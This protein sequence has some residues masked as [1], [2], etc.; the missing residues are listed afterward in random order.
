MPDSAG[1]AVVAYD[2]SGR[3]TGHWE[4]SLSFGTILFNHPKDPQP[5]SRP[6]RR[7]AEIAAPVALPEAAKEES[8]PPVEPAPAEAASE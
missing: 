2:T 1:S 4:N 5:E 6:E 8:A 3:K 7:L